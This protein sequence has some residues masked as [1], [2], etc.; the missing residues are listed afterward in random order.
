MLLQV[1]AP[2]VKNA[3]VICFL[4]HQR[5]GVGGGVGDKLGQETGRLGLGMRLELE[6][7]ERSGGYCGLSFG[8]WTR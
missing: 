1:T 6:R 4:L 2:H 7:K 3:E 8:N 5:G